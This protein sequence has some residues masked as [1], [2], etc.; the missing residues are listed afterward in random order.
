VKTITS[1]DTCEA[2]LT[3]YL[4]EHGEAPARDV[5]S[6]AKEMGF[7]HGTLWKA[8]TNIGVTS[9]RVREFAS[10]AIWRLDD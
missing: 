10:G 1:L 4:N 8:A 3:A 2:W 9:E 5:K 7:S 6:L